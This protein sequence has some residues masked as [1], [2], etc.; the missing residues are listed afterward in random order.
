MMTALMNTFLALSLAGAN[1]SPTVDVQAVVAS[2]EDGVVLVERKLTP[3]KLDQLR[4]RRFPE[5]SQRSQVSDGTLF[6]GSLFVAYPLA[7]DLVDQV[8]GRRWVGT[9]ARLELRRRENGRYEVV[10]IAAAR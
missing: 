10:G 3:A 7:A 8:H 4:R 1:P 5:V 6:D 2:L 9:E